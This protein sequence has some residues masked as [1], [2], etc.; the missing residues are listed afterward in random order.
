MVANTCSTY[1]Q[2]ASFQSPSFSLNHGQSQV[3]NRGF[4]SYN[5]NKNRGKGRF[6]QGSRFFA[7]RPT[8]SPLPLMLPNSN[9]GVLGSPPS[10][11][12]QSPPA[13]MVPICQLCNSKGHIALFCGNSSPQHAKCHICGRSNHTTWYCFY[14][15]KGPN[16]IWVHTNASYSPQLSYPMP[17]QNL[18][19]TSYQ[20]SSQHLS[21]PFALNR[22]SQQPPM[23]AKHTRLNS[24]SP[25]SCSLG[26][27]QV[28]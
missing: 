12:F 7:A 14:N 27:S 1:T 2:G 5:G 4:Q 9:P 6:T 11:Q 18:Q 8:F 24:A 26:P 15:D 23:Q 16:Y 19:Y 21:V 25:S 17:P 20:A 3:N 28:G 13:S 10:Q 22:E